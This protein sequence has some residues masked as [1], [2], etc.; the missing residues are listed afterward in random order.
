[1]MNRVAPASGKASLAFTEL[2]IQL[3]QKLVLAEKTHPPT[4]PPPLQSCLLQLAQLGGHLNRRHD[5]QPGNTV[6]W[7][8]TARLTD[9]ELGFQ[10]SAQ[11][12]GN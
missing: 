1:M 6:I 3:L 7:R 10:L 2:E 12:V 8:G 4:R 9:I 11:L 5:A